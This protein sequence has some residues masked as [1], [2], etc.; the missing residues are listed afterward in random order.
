[1]QTYSDEFIVTNDRVISMGTRHLHWELRERTESRELKLERV[2]VQSLNSSGMRVGQGSV[3]SLMPLDE[4]AY[5]VL[6]NA[7]V[8]EGY[9]AFAY[10]SKCKRPGDLNGMDQLA[11]IKIYGIFPPHQFDG[12]D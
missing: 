5:T 1:M 10:F 2:V 9:N 3:S 11:A 8:K 4:E 12:D 6:E 7:E